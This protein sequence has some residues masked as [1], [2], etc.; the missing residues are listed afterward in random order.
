MAEPQPQKTADTDTYSQ[1]PLCHGVGWAVN[2]KQRASDSPCRLCR[3]TGVVAEKCV[4]GRPA[5]MDRA[6]YLGENR[7]YC[8]ASECRAIIEAEI[9]AKDPNERPPASGFMGTWWNKDADEDQDFWSRMG[10]C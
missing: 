7:Y 8:G 5:F 1:C 3:G 6:G 9:G 10:C 4:C 2:P